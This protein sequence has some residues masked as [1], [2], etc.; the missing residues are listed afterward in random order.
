VR[1]DASY[2]QAVDT[3][4]QAAG[5]EARDAVLGRKNTLTRKDTLQLAAVVREQPAE[6]AAA[7]VRSA[8]QG[9]RAM[10][11][12]PE[13]PG[14]SSLADV[15][16]GGWQ[17]PSSSPLA[18]APPSPAP[19]PLAP[20]PA[21]AGLAELEARLAE[22]EAENTALRKS[23][24]SR[25]ALTSSASVEWYT[26][27]EYIDAAR[28]VLGGIDLDPASC[29][30]ANA[31]VHARQ[32]Y[33]AA[34]NGLALP[35][36]GRLWLNAPYGWDEDGDSRQ[37]VWSAHLLEAYRDRAI[38]ASVS[39][40][41]VATGSAW[42][43]ALWDVPLCFPDHRIRYIGPG[44]VASKQPTHANVFAYLGDDVAAFAREFV[45]FGRIVVPSFDG[46]SES[47]GRAR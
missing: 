4:A 2:A 30:E 15:H 46:I 29:D 35:W 38:K 25:R 18:M 24:G 22:L 12:P 8:L 44:G 27:P 42:F 13:G 10:L 14:A 21:P 32:C 26:P 47:Y 40:W 3:L 20:A 33:T 11:T 5:A 23:K 41:N 16:G 45:Q 6:D 17:E 34:D 28:R 1:R 31:I 9:D 37:A 7:T 43:Q 36:F 19:S 39:L